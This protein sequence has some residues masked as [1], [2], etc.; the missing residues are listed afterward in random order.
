M[1]SPTPLIFLTNCLLNPLHYKKLNLPL[2]FIAFGITEGK[3]YKHFRNT[4]TFI[5]PVNNSKRWGNSV[6]YGGIFFCPDVDFYLRILDAYHLC[7]LSTLGKNHI[8]DLHHRIISHIIPIYFNTLEELSKLQYKEG[9]KLPTHT[10]VG[11]VK[12]PKIAKR[13]YKPFVSYRIKDGID[14][15]HF[16]NLYKELNK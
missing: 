16:K 1:N 9:D 11:N 6:V 7:S 12:H 13:M 14:V 8:R 5:M 10:Y 3:M 2:E 15:K 4:G